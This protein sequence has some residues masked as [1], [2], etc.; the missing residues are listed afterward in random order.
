MKRFA[1]ITAGL[2]AAAILC[3]C[4]K[5]PD[6]S[7]SE[8]ESSESVSSQ[9][10]GG[11]EFGLKDSFAPNEHTVVNQ[12]FTKKYEAEKGAFNGRAFDENGE[13]LQNPDKGGYVRLQKNQYLTQVAMVT[14]SQFYRVVISV[15]SE[16]GAA[17][18]LQLGD[19]VEGAYTIGK[20][21]SEESGEDDYKLYAVD[22]LYMS[23]GMNSLKFI[24]ESG[25]ADIDF[26]IVE[27]S[28]A[29]DDANY[30]VGSACVSKNASSAT[31]QLMMMFSEYYGKLSFTAQNVS[32]G[33]N[34]E[35]DAIFGETKRYPAIRVS[36]LSL[37]LKDDDHSKEVMKNDL[38]LAKSWD[39]DGGICAYTWHW[40]SPNALRGTEVKLFDAENALGKAEPEEMGML[41]D[42]AMELQLSN[43]LIT[44][45]AVSILKDLDTLA[46]T[47]KTL[48]DADIPVLFEPIPDGDAGLFWWGKSAESYKTLWKL[49][50]VRLTQYNGL[51][52][53]IWVWN[54]SDFDFYPGDDY[55]DIIGQ[56]FYEKTNSSF[57]GR[58]AAI[59]ENNASERKMLAV[60]ACASLPGVDFMWRDN[61]MW[62]WTAPDCGEYI[63][64][65]AGGGQFHLTEKYTKRAAFRN[66]YNNKKCVTRDELSELGY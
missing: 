38:E 23:A 56:S 3:G 65:G 27:N 5:I 13:E 33:S 40:Y 19:N 31:T 15:R 17:I 39:K 47:L 60:T 24:A 16:N 59:A 51:K 21:T 48:D 61:A 52:N 30:K 50:F 42:A 55:V 58:F 64:D 37:A 36:E 62:L 45:D 54:N 26:V 18:K 14:S 32:C 7:K 22:H 66:A 29:V 57:A 25:E 20:T 34:A 28:E 6:A 49:A 2:L 11:G 8:P 35:I 63:L 53:L 4:E 1:K 46:E 12:S 43:E 10:S 9:T 44:K 41:D